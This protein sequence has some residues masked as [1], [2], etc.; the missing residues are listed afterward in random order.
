MDGDVHNLMAPLSRHAWLQELSMTAKAAES[1]GEGLLTASRQAIIGQ[2]GLLGRPATLSQLLHELL[3]LWRLI[4][5][6]LVFFL[7][8][9]CS[10]SWCC[11]R[12]HYRARSYS[13]KYTRIM[14][15][16]GIAPAGV[17]L[18]HCSTSA[19]FCAK[20]EVPSQ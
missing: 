1:K 10:C 17:R 8:W 11:S 3:Y 13:Y 5:T 18:Q 16:S 15:L 4:H 7:P 12:R 20:A 14:K 2:A 9:P 6:F 19:H